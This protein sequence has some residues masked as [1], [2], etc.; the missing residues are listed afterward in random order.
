MKCAIIGKGNVGTAIGNGLI[1]AGHEVRYGHRGTMEPVHE[2]AAWGEVVLLAV[3]YTGVKDAVQSIGSAADGKTLIDVTNALTPAMDLAIGH[4][5][6][7]AEELQ[8]MLPRAHVVK[9][10]NTVF[11]QNQGSGRVGTE[12]LTAFIAGDDP[13]ARKT[14]LQLAGDI[15]FDPVDVGGL[16]SARYLEPMA[17]MLISLGYGMNMGTKIGY[18]LVKG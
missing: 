3:P 13:G 17:V 1:R 5:T 14:A 9:A 10:F 6:S 7:A 16:K 15:G 11:A 8:K 2:A 4:S 12:Q 18:R